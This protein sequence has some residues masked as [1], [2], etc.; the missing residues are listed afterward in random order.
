MYTNSQKEETTLQA[1][2]ERIKNMQK[3]YREKQADVKKQYPYQT[4]RSFL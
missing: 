1:V 3:F 4:G 2:R